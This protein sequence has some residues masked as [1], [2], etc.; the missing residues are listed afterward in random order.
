MS[1]SAIWLNNAIL[2]AVL[3]SVKVPD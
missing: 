2:G 1:N 3:Y